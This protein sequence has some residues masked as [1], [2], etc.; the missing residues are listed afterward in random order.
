M[1]YLNLFLRFDAMIRH[2]EIQIGKAANDNAPTALSWLYYGFLLGLKETT[3]DPVEY[4]S[5]TDELR[6]ME[7]ML[8]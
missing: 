1:D 7:R 6:R 8:I 2:I 5:V 4:L 3:Q